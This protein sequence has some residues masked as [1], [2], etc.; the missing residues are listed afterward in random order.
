MYGAE[1]AIATSSGQNDS[2]MFELNLHDER[3]LPFE[4]HG[5]VCRLRIEMPQDNNYMPMEPLTDFMLT[6][7]HT[8]REGGYPL[9]GV[10]KESAR[11]H[12]PGAG[13][14]YFDM[15]HDF[16]DAWQLLQNWCREKKSGA[17][18]A[19][20]LERKMFPYVPALGELAITGMAIVFQSADHEPCGCEAGECPCP[21]GCHP[22]CHVVEFRH[23]RQKHNDEASHVSCL[24]C[25]EAPELYY[26]IFDTRFGP[27]GR[28]HQRTEVEFRFPENIGELER[29]YVLCRYARWEQPC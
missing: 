29:V 21:Q 2:G 6:L 7:N 14:C 19:F 20:G 8:T 1:E 22:D 18:L 27:V 3:R 5:A 26:G 4:F 25:A 15:R 11:K 10:A 28:D 24:S 17:R 12:L 9:A 23:G 16:P 13:W